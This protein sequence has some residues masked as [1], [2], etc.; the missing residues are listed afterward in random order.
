MKQFL[1][2]ILLTCGA[3]LQSPAQLTLEVPQKFYV[4]QRWFS[5]TNTFDIETDQ[6]KLGTVDRKFFSLSPVQYNFYDN[7]QQ[8]QAKAK[9][10]WLSWGATFDVT[11]SL[12]APIGCV[13][14]KI[15]TFFPTFEMISPVGEILAQAKMNFWGTKY[16]LS[17][18]VTKLEMATLSRSF[19]RLKDNWTVNLTNPALFLQKQIDLRLFILVMAFQ[20]DRDLWSRK[21]KYVLLEELTQGDNTLVYTMDEPTNMLL[22][23]SDGILDVFHAELKAYR[24]IVGAVA[25]SGEDFAHVEQ[26]AEARLL[27]AETAHQ[28]ISEQVRIARGYGVLRPLLDGDALTSGEKS[29]LLKLLEHLK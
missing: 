13:D 11:D 18:P 16:T 21:S 1:L 12:D 27:E 15:F 5:L 28:P 24:T 19:F 4:K 29:A 10:R 17:D 2:F 3:P 6:F 14:E 9:M 8:L 20:T 22:Q 25:P 26:L 7:A 23:P